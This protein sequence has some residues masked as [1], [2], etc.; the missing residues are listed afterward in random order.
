MGV[1][2][3]QEQKFIGM[4]RKEISV[5]YAE[6][7]Y[8]VKALYPYTPNDPL[9]GQQWGPKAIKADRAWDI[10]RGNHSI[11]IAIV[12][13][14]INYTHEDLAGNYVLG[15][16]DWINDDSDPKDDHGHGTHCAGIATAVLNNSKGIA[17]IANVSIMAEKV[18]N[19]SGFGSSW[20]VSQGIEHAADQGAD[21]IS[22]SLGSDSPSQLLKEACEYAWD[23]GCVLVAAAGNENAPIVYPA[24]FDTVIAVGALENETKR[25]WWSNHGPELELMAPGVNIL[26]TY[27]PGNSYAYGSGT[28]MAAPHV[29]GVA[30][31][32]WSNCP[33]FTNQKVREYLNSTAD[34]LGEPGWDSYYGWGRVDAEGAIEAL[35]FLLQN[36][37]TGWN[38]ISLPLIPDDNS[39]GA[40]LS[41][42]SGEY[43]L[44]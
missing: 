24:A 8:I 23:S 19:E 9:Y 33:D 25:V 37:T 3:L 39:T 6:P 27:C 13:T 29:A 18:L 34:D 7:N 35:S 17:G 21:V 4:I 30:A 22:L 10:Q 44:A 11:K 32:V 26:S 43:S 15:G 38:L 2:K 41:S 14:G 16:Y 20:T 40:V 5:K 42:L 12:D 1:D 31:L 36:I 28:S